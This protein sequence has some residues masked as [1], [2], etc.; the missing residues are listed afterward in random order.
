MIRIKFF[1]LDRA[2]KS[3]VTSSFIILMDEN[4]LGEKV[5]AQRM[6]IQRAMPSCTVVAL[7][8]TGEFV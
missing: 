2:T 7:I 4:M 1:A 6:V 5:E 8:E 3:M